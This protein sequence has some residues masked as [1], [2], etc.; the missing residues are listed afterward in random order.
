M[1]LS[2]VLQQKRHIGYSKLN[3]E[4][5]QSSSEDECLD[6]HTDVEGERQLCGSFNE[7]DELEYRSLW[8]SNCEDGEITEQESEDEDSKIE[9]CVKSGDLIR[10]KQILKRREE[11]CKQLQKEG[12]Q[13]ESDPETRQ[14][15]QNS[16]TF[17]G[18]K[19]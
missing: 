14:E 3:A 9:D 16:T 1:S 18:A 2:R 19:K 17:K 11:D 12:G 10:L 7:E 4:V 5:E 6:V 15:N 13:Q 8:G